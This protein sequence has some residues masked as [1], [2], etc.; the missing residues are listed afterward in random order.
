MLVV[1]YHGTVG[2]LLYVSWIQIELC[3]EKWTTAP[4]D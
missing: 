4:S 2:T 1:V 3:F